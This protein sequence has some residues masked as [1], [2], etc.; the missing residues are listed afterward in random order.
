MT[1]IDFIQYTFQRSF[2]M[3]GLGRSVFNLSLEMKFWF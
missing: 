1:G 2:L 3:T